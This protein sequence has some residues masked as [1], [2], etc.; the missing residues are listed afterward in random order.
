MNVSTR[1]PGAAQREVVR[2]RT[3]TPVS[4]CQESWA[5][6]RRRTADALRL[7]RGTDLLRPRDEERGEA[8]LDVVRDHLGGAVLGV[9]QAAGARE[10]LVLAGDVERH[11]RERLAGHHDL[12]GGEL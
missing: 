8:R 4:R 1:V 6:A 9:A 3:G 5:P 12:A 7:V 2:C 11:P 10:A